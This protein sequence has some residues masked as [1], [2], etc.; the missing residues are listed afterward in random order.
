MMHSARGRS[1]GNRGLRKTPRVLLI[2]A[3]FSLGGCLGHASAPLLSSH[4]IPLITYSAAQQKQAAAELA[5]L[6]PNS[7]I[8]VMITD[9]GKVRA[10]LRAQ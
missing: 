4:T 8:G 9:Y 6:P 7:Q 1:W 10:I 5:K 3:L 2:M